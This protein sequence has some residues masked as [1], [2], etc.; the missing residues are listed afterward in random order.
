MS[1]NINDINQLSHDEIK[2]KR[3]EANSGTN[4][5]FIF[6][7]KIKNGEIKTVEVH[8]SSIETDTKTLLFSI[9][10]D[11]T[12][13]KVLEEDLKNQKEEFE[14][15][16][17]NTQIGVMYI[18]GDRTLIKANP[19]LST[20]FGYDSPEEMVG[21]NMRSF[22]LSQE[23][24]IEYGKLNFNSL[25]NGIKRNI[26][27]PLRKKDGSKIWVSATG[28]AIDN[29]IP[30][31]L[32]KGVL[33]TIEDIT[34]QKEFEENLKDER[35][36][37][38]HLLDLAGSIVIAIDKN[39][40]ITLINKSGCEL[41]EESE[42]NILGKNWFDNYLVSDEKQFV[43]DKF[44]QMMDG[45]LEN[46]EYVEN[47]IKTK[48]NKEYIIAWHNS[49]T[50]DQ[51]GKI[52]G[53][54]SSGIDI[55][56]KKQLDN[57]ML[58]QKEEFEI[59]FN[60][61]KDGIAIVDLESNFLNCN[62]SYCEMLDYSKDELLTKSCIELGIKEDRDKSFE[63][64]EEVINRGFTTNFQK[65]CFTK[66]KRIIYVNMTGSL[67][68]DKKHILLITKDV[69]DTKILEEQSKLASM[70]EM[71]GNISHQWR[72]PL[73]IITTASTGVLFYKE[74]GNLSDELLEKEMNMI[75][76]Q[77]QYL[78]RTIDDFKNFIKNDQE[79]T[80]IS[81]KE[82]VEYALKL[83]Q[84]TV[85]NNYIKVVTEL[86][87]DI[88]IHGN[89][90]ELVQSFINIINNAKDAL[91]ENTKEDD[92]Y[93]L[94]STQKVADSL[95]LKIIDSGNGIDSKHIERIF[96]PYFT[97]KHQSVGTGIGLSMVHKILHEKYHAIIDVYNDSFSIDDKKLYGAC[98][99]ISLND[100]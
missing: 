72:Q 33:W 44:T 12:E 24:F 8:A 11:I 91:K 55:T 9:V 62:D 59:I 71:I 5:R 46:A 49:S 23:N 99:A 87:E 73:S 31:D 16:F 94:L 1:L 56:E 92:R 79:E 54:L 41:L 17:N 43:K 75:N 48:N 77:A 27:Y 61:S 26:E 42:D 67:L 52:T 86:D 29:K 96:E 22:H 50:F 18:T 2:E 100:K 30:A 85:K 34:I 66:D 51:E 25:K 83:T 57:K 36:Y 32:S 81:I 84:A 69:T 53:L 19:R 89:Q 80:M 28:K 74:M 95:E 78:S 93:I 90:N 98:F 76:E 60:S 4:N 14:L 7:H 3:K 15:I 97:T 70:G 6:Q 68:P 10:E 38:Q 35:D 37:S 40:D 65:R 20:M 82:A 39:G 13:V 63:A 64:M 21:L 88:Q 47:S 45:K 58:A